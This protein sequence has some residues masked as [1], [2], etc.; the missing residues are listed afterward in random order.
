MKTII[1]SGL[2]L[3]SL[4]AFTFSIAP[5]FQ[6][7]RVLASGISLPVSQLSISE[8]LGLLILGVGIIG[9]ARIGRKRFLKA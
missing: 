8:P 9:L 2:V 4:L 6:D 5:Y 7:A 1:K 3:I